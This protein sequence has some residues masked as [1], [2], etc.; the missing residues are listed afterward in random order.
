MTKS[1]MVRRFLRN[2]LAI[3]G[4]IWLLIVLITAI[5]A[6]VIERYS[7]SEVN[8]D[9]RSS[10]PSKKH[11]LGTDSIG[12]DVWSR[13]VNGA[14]ISL[15]VVAISV[16]GSVLIGTLIGATSGLSG[17]VLDT[18][19]QRLTEVFMSLP[20][21][22]V[23]LVFMAIT[24]PGLWSLLAALIIFGWT[25][26]ARVVRG[27][28]L[29]VREEEYVEAARALGGSASRILFKHA[30]PA[31]VPSILVNATLKAATFVLAEAS[32]SFLGYG[33]QPPT[34]SW[35][36]VLAEAQQMEILTQMPWMW[37][38][39]GVAITLT[40]LAFNFAGDGLRDAVS[41]REKQTV[42]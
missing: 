38:P 30:L 9:S 4:I 2:R 31:C 27:E 19:L 25:D 39:P 28:M 40:I 41:P 35:G 14:R 5:G 29:S 8:L 3:F 42:I 18:L 1:K 21:L 6:P 11:W 24:S 37:I 10:P 7:M 34:P 12:R 26:T 36:I 32:L 13:T 15:L 17:G 20:L 33:V 16:T 22:I 23:A